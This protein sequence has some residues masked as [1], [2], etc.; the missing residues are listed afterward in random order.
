MPAAGNEAEG[1]ER[2][3]RIVRSF[4]ANLSHYRS[5]NFPETAARNQFIDPFFEALGWDV[6][7]EGGAGP[8]R[9]VVVENRQRTS[10][11]A[12]GEEEWDD[13]LTAEELAERSTETRF[14]D[15][16]FRID[17]RD[18]FVAE[19][20][21]PS[22]NLA[23]KAPS[24]Q[25]KSYAW[26]MRLPIAVLTDFE[27]L[28]VFDARHRPHYDE[29]DAG[30]VPGLGLRFSEY[31]DNWPSIW[32]LLSREAV[33]AG[34]LDAFI[35][36]HPARGAHPVDRSFL[37]EL[38]LWRVRIAADLFDRNPD[39]NHWEIAEA[40]QRIL[41]RVVFVR[42]MEDRGIVTEPILRRHGCVPDLV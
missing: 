18:M 24:F 27:E 16:V 29:P 7:D 21:K 25:A 15:Y 12:A 22:V 9:D 1:R 17:M 40:T 14:P 28:R 13:D 32:G 37:A 11:T 35:A 38:A 20:K 4:G 26:T 31:V 34:A 42:V 33:L 2:V 36:R 19:A 5:P 3:A 30:M 39:L 10:A 23:R 41:D 6:A 8:R